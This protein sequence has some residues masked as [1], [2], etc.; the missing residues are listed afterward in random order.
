MWVARRYIETDEKS[1]VWLL[2]V[3]PT[4]N[5]FVMVSAP[6]ASYTLADTNVP[7]AG[8]SGVES[9]KSRNFLFNFFS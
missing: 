3:F 4:I 5:P 1:D 9:V 2:E 8:T 7:A 6:D